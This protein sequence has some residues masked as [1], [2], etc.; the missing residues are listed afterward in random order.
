MI[1]PL[2]DQMGIEEQGHTD[3]FSANIDSANT[4]QRSGQNF[5]C[6]EVEEQLKEF[7][8]GG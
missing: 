6:L 2:L 1:V 5:Y 8:Q 7:G 3:T 4:G